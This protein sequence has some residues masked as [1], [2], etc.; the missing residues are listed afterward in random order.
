MIETAQAPFSAETVALL[1]AAGW[2]FA[3]GMVAG[4]LGAGLAVWRGRNALIWY[5]AGMAFPPAAL[6]PIFLETID[7]RERLGGP[8]RLIQPKAGAPVM[9]GTR[10]PPGAPGIGR[11]PPRP[12][13]RL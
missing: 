11:P 3:I 8:P 2:Y 9:P 1:N 13:G 6:A 12:P 10:P 7:P 5:L 4:L